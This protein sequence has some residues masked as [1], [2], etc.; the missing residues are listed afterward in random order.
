MRLSRPVNVCTDLDVNVPLIPVPRC[1]ANQSRFNSPIAAAPHD[2]A[3]LASGFEYHG[4]NYA[5]LSAIAQRVT[6][7]RWNGFHFFGLKQEWKHE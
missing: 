1:A 7:T 2:I 4:K 3:V 6:G 5:S